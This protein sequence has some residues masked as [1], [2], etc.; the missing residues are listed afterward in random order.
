MK[1]PCDWPLGHLVWVPFFR[2]QQGGVDNCTPKPLEF[3]A[4]C[5]LLCRERFTTTMQHKERLRVSRL[6]AYY[7]KRD[8]ICP[9][10]ANEAQNKTERTFEDVW[11]AFCKQVQHAFNPKPF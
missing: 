10:R 7:A 4:L 1:T 3:M 8:A 2:A 9:E 6:E 11:R 5:W